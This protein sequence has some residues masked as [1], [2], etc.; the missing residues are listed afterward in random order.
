MP[1]PYLEMCGGGGRGAG[2]S[3][4]S[5]TGMVALLLVVA[6]TSPPK[7]IID[8]HPIQGRE[9]HYIP[10]LGGWI[11]GADR[12]ALGYLILRF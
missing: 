12:H 7:K 11:K 1:D 8:E 9:S 4:G 2:P 10:P 3:P 5:A 6:P